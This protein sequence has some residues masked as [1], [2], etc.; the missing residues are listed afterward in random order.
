M[1][2]SSSPPAV[3]DAM[4]C[5]VRSDLGAEGDAVALQTLCSI[6]ASGEGTPGEIAS[7]ALERLN[8]ALLSRDRRFALPLISKY[9]ADR[10]VSLLALGVFCVAGDELRGISSLV[11]TLLLG[12]NATGKDLLARLAKGWSS[13]TARE[14]LVLRVREL[15][16]DRAARARLRPRNDTAV[17]RIARSYFL[18]DVPEVRE[19]IVAHVASR[20]GGG[21]WPR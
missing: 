8:A 12:K 1:Q 3:D 11:G 16:L 6:A 17:E 5:E 7:I 20:L 13:A 2:T 4:R 14:G 10:V 9:L 19:Q 18:V 15:V 21:P